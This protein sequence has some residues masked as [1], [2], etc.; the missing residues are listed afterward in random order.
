[1]TLKITA[2]DN[3][4]AERL[5]QDA[6]PELCAELAAGPTVVEPNDVIALLN[7]HGLYLISAAPL[8]DR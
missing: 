4:E 7:E 1:M 6:L 5:L 8:E 3:A 2:E